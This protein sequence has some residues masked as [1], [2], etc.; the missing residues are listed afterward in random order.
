MKVTPSFLPLASYRC[1]FL[2]VPGLSLH[3]GPRALGGC[4][5]TWKVTIASSFHFFFLLFCRPRPRPTVELAGGV[6][7]Q[8]ALV[9]GGP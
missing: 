9:A 7:R 2:Y 6:H 5:L 1:V 4:A 3:R 8:S